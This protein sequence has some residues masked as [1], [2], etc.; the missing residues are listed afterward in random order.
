MGDWQTIDGIQ[1]KELYAPKRVLEL[2]DQRIQGRR[3]FLTA[4]ADRL[5][6][7]SAVAGQVQAIGD[8]VDISSP[9]SYP[10]FPILR[11]AEAAIDGMGVAG[12]A[13]ADS[14]ASYDFAQIMVTYRN[15]NFEGEGGTFRPDDPTQLRSINITLSGSFLQAPQNHY[16]WKFEID[17]KTPIPEEKR[18]YIDEPVGIVMPLL[19]IAVTDHRVPDLNIALWW[20]SVGTINENEFE[21][22]DAEHLLYLGLDS[23]ISFNFTSGTPW[24]ITH[25]FVA[26]SR[27]WNTFLRPGGTANKDRTADR[28]WQ[29]IE[30]PPYQLL[31][32][33][34]LFASGVPPE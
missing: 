5:P 13:G 2:R 33:E 4:W 24:S 11:A 17:G 7:L 23:R 9:V 30:P 34:T 16:Y 18:E 28:Q 12:Q 20:G 21:G 26:R 32:F 14:M 31:D 29:A 15:F 10:D 3:T 1:F 25:K 8:D 22:V 6:F 19:N 27:S